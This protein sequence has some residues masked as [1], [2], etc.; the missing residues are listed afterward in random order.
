M[1]YT[2]ALLGGAPAGSPRGHWSAGWRGGAEVWPYF[3]G[4]DEAYRNVLFHGPQFQALM[5]VEALGPEG[6]LGRVKAA[7]LPA[8]WMQTPPFEQWVTEPLAIDALFQLLILWSVE[9]LGAPCLPCRVGSFRQYRPF[10][11]TSYSVAVHVTAR[12][13]GTLLANAAFVDS[14]G[15]I[16]AEFRGAECTF[17]AGLDEAFRRNTLASTALS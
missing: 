4:L 11:G 17:N 12:R 8:E 2:T 1:A 14:A 13:V 15:E 5:S 16:V 9:T 7:P 10:T 3:R 6:V